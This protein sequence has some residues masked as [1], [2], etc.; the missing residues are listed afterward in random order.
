VL[1]TDATSRLLRRSFITYVAKG[2]DE[3]RTSRD[4][5]TI[6]IV[7]K[8]MTLLPRSPWSSKQTYLRSEVSSWKRNIKISPMD[9]KPFKDEASWIRFKNAFLPPL[10]LTDSDI[11]LTLTT[12]STI[13]IS[14]RSNADGFTNP[15]RHYSSASRKSIVTKHIDDKNTRK[16]WEELCEYYDHSMSA[17]I[18]SGKISTY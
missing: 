4:P 16:I 6:Y 3:F 15:S 13:S 17:H 5:P 18:Q 14:I 7:R 9:Y 10:N 8:P 11:S 1:L 12:S 2:T